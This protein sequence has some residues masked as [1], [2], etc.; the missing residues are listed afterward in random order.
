MYA[1]P[2]N[3]LDLGPI[4]GMDPDWFL[5][6]LHC[7]D[8]IQQRL[9]KERLQT[10]DYKDTLKFLRTYFPRSGRLIEVG[11]SFGFLGSFFKKSGWEVTGVDPNRGL[12]RYAEAELLLNVIP[13]SLEKA[14]IPA[15]SVSVVL[16][17]HV[18]EH[19]ADPKAS[20]SCVYKILK[21]GGVLVLETP[22]YDTRMFQWLGK[23]ERSIR[24]DGHIY[25]FT[26]TSLKELARRSGFELIR[27]DYVGRSLTLD[28]V[29][30]NL[31][32]ILKNNFVAGL[33]GKLSHLLRL[34]SFWIYLNLRDSQRIYLRK[35]LRE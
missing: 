24:C 4:E 10:R 15:N 26:S 11:S 3:A 32:V 17:M 18:I 12:C 8:W 30:Y 5:S 29:F 25:F 7:R 9:K 14:D 13:S 28:R 27:L 23:R 31:G 35:P 33:L 21:P 34:H 6:H 22:R 16:M 2:R 1:N 20:L 19:L